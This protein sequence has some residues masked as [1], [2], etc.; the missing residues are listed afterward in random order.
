MQ[1]DYTKTAAGRYG[2]F[3]RRHGDF[4]W[5]SYGRSR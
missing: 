5:C 4:G 1:Y 2:L 3:G